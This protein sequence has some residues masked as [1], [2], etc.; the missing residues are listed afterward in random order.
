MP[1]ELAL[2]LTPKR[3]RMSIDKTAKHQITRHPCYSSPCYSSPCYSIPCYSTSPNPG[4]FFS[5]NPSTTYSVTYNASSNYSPPV[6]VLL[7]PIR[8]RH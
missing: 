2:I 3:N 1:G 8:K 4:Y 5:H 7:L 6:H